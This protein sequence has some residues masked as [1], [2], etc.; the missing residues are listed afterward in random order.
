M[1]N[2]FRDDE[3]SPYAQIIICVVDCVDTLLFMK[4]IMQRVTAQ[5]WLIRED[6]SNTDMVKFN[7]PFINSWIVS[8]P[9][10]WKVSFAPD[11]FI[12]QVQMSEFKLFDVFLNLA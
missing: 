8:Y 4:P 6:E 2:P 7:A 1:P 12:V 3:A 11:P 5:Q 9:C 10:R